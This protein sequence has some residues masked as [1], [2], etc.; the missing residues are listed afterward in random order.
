MKRHL[1]AATT[2]NMRTPRSNVSVIL[3]STAAFAFGCGGTETS[4]GTPNN[5]TGGTANF[6][7][8]IG[9]APAGGTAG[10]VGT[11]GAAG[12][13]LGSGGVP[14]FCSTPPQDWLPAMKVCQVNTDCAVVP[15]YSCCGPGTIYGLSLKSE[16]QYK[17][18]FTTTPP[19]GCPPLG[20]ASQ[21]RTEDG[22]GVDAALV[23]DA[24]S[25]AAR[26]V[27][28]GGGQKEC[29]STLSGSCVHNVTRCA[30]GDTCSD[31]CGAKC[32]CQ[33]GYVNC[34]RPSGACSMPTQA[35]QYVT[36]PG[37]PSGPTC[38]CASAGA[39]WSCQP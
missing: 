7:G 12:G 39:P 33:N 19:Q 15:T 22:Q 30:A 32:I 20:C 26:C 24:V 28:S 16:P 23:G 14:A 5:S 27:D 35:C 2:F 9:G 36:T 3:L 25:V 8:S 11:G 13:T 6:D 1:A 10:V 29:T 31:L 37:A 18:C 38:T 21:G 17:Q 34:A 4:T